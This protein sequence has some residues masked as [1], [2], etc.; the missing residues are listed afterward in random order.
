M[1]RLIEFIGNHWEL[2]SVFLALLVAL[3]AV[4]TRRAGQT[5]TA[6]YATHLINKQNALVLDIRDSNEFSAGHI[7]GAL[8]IPYAKVKERISELESYRECPIILVCKLGQHS[9]TVGKWLR[10][11]KFRNIQRLSGGI[12]GWVSDQL[13]L[14]KK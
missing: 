1:A 14:V 9:G 3:F 4:E 12:S 13:P 10:E 7:P 8:N 11:K 6:L 5:V 2:V